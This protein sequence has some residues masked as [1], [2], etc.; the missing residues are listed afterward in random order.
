M[1]YLLLFFYLVV[2]IIPVYA[3]GKYYYN[4]DTIKE[5]NKLL[6]KM[7]FSGFISGI[8]VIYISL[9]F[10]A[11][12][13]S[14]N[15]NN[16]LNIIYLLLYCFLFISL[17][18]ELS[19]FIMIY[20]TGYNNKEFDQAYDIVLYSVL[21]GLGFACFENFVYILTEELSLIT[22]LIRGITAVPAHACFQTFM[23]YYLYKSKKSN[24]KRY[25]FLS[26]FIPFLFHGLYDFI[27]FS[28]TNLVIIYFILLLA[29]IFPLSIFKIKELI[30]IDK[31][32]M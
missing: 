11:I 17:I 20:K 31:K 25:I 5:P 26:I 1:K 30:N 15:D 13:P 8:I 6:K 12:F 2:A 22:I 19:K 24:K 9:V 21:V 10:L 18:E 28:G 14:L 4:K 7:F 27:I 29:I 3:I 32:N 23:G 16:S